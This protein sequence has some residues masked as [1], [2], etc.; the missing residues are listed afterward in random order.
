MQ[1]DRTAQAGNTD[2]RKHW[3]VYH[4]PQKVTN[5]EKEETGNIERTQAW[6]RAQSGQGG[7]S[8]KASTGLRLPAR[9]WLLRMSV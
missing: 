4:V 7:L 1:Q 6:R 3:K 5:D 2:D 8:N 9:E